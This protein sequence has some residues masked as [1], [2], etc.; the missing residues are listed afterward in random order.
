MKSTSYGI[1]AALGIVVGCGSTSASDP[2]SGFELSTDGSG[3]SSGAGGGSTSSGA[4]SGSTG[5]VSSTS[6]DDAT[7]ASS[8]DAQSPLQPSDASTPCASSCSGCC[9][10]TGACNDG[11]QSLACG[12][13]G[14][15]C[16]LCAPGQSCSMG[17]CT[18]PAP[19]ADS[20]A[21]N[22]CNSKIC[23]DAGDCLV[24]GCFNGCTGWFGHCL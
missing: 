13:G 3:T 17:S 15:T 24:A 6:G 16:Q 8:D 12:A 4:G 10:V 19:K 20:G 5:E 22:A 23:W 9:D 1:L 21:P 7:A 2:T 11:T 14:A 18:T